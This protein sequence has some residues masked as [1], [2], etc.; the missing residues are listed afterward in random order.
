VQRSLSDR[1]AGEDDGALAAAET[2]DEVPDLARRTAP[3]RRTGRTG[4]TLDELPPLPAVPWEMRRSFQTA[5]L[6]S[7]MTHDS[8]PDLIGVTMQQ[9][10][11]SLPDLSEASELSEQSC[12]EGG[13]SICSDHSGQQLR[14]HPPFS[15]RRA[16]SPEES[17]NRAMS[18]QPPEEERQARGR[19]LNITGAMAARLPGVGSEIRVR[20]LSAGRSVQ[21]VVTDTDGDNVRVM[22]S[23][24]GRFC[25][26]TVAK[27]E[28]LATQAE[29]GELVERAGDG[30]GV[31]LVAAQTAQA[32][33]EPEDQ[34]YLSQ[35][36]G[37]PAAHPAPVFLQ[38]SAPANGSLIADSDI[39]VMPQQEETRGR[40][41][42]RSELAIGSTV[43]VRSSSLGRC[44]EG[45]VT[46][47]TNDRVRV[48]YFMNGRCCTKAIERACLDMQLP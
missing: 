29:F 25:V 31:Q 40:Q 41:R 34:T 47:V 16:S 17:R 7:V 9:T 6:G 30:G 5:T 21:A 28:Y 3:R 11:G 35:Q 23:V 44:V 8:M 4:G 32:P 18:W 22:Y 38:A 42:N 13:G 37:L 48:Q 45:V 33:A 15:G 10:Q 2:D 39:Q 36:S 19:Q 14:E 20:S 1:S 27:A 26:R 24:G 43:A 46:D 12:V